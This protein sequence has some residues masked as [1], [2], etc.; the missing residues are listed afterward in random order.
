MTKFLMAIVPTAITMTAQMS[1]AIAKQARHLTRV[2]TA[3]MLV[4]VTLMM[5]GCF[6][7]KDLGGWHFNRAADSMTDVSTYRVV[8]RG[9]NES[10]GLQSTSRRLLA[11]QCDSANSRGISAV[12]ALS[13]VVGS[14]ITDVGYRNPRPYA[15]FRVDENAPFRFA[16]RRTASWWSTIGGVPSALIDQMQKGKMLRV[17]AGD[18]IYLYPLG[19]AKDPLARL[20]DS[21]PFS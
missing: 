21:C 19:G 16:I 11:F 6:T 1:M 5:V 3:A 7:E 17:Q 4:A 13:G 9:Y 8:K 2:L 10:I 15:L 12:E 20:M 14:T 18:Y